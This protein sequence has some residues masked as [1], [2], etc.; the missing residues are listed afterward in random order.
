ME[1]KKRLTC[2]GLSSNIAD[3]MDKQ[4]VD[5]IP[6]RDLYKLYKSLVRCHKLG[7][8]YVRQRAVNEATVL[9]RIIKSTK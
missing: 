8:R 5:N 9:M 6:G 3:F 1:N 2:S 7:V 4:N